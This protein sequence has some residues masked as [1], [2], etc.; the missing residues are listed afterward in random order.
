MTDMHGFR[1]RTAHEL[2]KGVWWYRRLYG[3]PPGQVRCHPATFLEWVKNSM[4]A[5][6]FPSSLDEVRVLGM[7]IEPDDGLEVGDT[8]LPPPA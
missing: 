3:V 2:I 5:P 4:T 7:P 1:A 6:P 8:V